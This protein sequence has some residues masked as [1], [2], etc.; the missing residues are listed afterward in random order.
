MGWKKRE[1]IEIPRE[2]PKRFHLQVYRALS[3]ELIEEWEADQLLND[4]LTTSSPRSLIERRAFLQLPTELRRNLL[5][6]QAK[7][8]EDYYERDTEWGD[9]VEDCVPK[10]GRDVR[11]TEVPNDI[12]C[13]GKF[14][15]LIGTIDHGD[16]MLGAIIG[17]IVGSIYEWDRI[18][19]KDFD[20]FDERCQFTD[21]TVCTAAVADILLHDL[22]PAPAMQEWC[23]RYPGARLRRLFQPMD[24]L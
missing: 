16:I 3:E 9:L 11:P 21:D 20:F 23:R 12:A 2:K 10:L 1:P 7:Q 17:D 18:K 4:S 24:L 6:E 15:T 19:T 5:R 14:H 8:M 22:P 13:S